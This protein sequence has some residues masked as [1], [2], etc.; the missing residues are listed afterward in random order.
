[1]KRFTDALCSKRE[2]Q[3]HTSKKKKKR[4]EKK[5]K[6]EAGKTRNCRPL[7]NH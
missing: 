4:K 6:V 2:Q 5:K 7:I 1:M 3:E